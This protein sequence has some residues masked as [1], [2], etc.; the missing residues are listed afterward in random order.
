MCCFSSGWHGGHRLWSVIHDAQAGIEHLEFEGEMPAGFDD[1]RRELL[2]QQHAAD[3]RRR[4]RRLP[5]LFRRAEPDGVDYV[6]DIPLETA[7][8]ATGFSYNETEPADGFVV[9]RAAG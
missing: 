7:K 2:A 8:R 6:F 5:D 3:G 1:I 9:L 4:S